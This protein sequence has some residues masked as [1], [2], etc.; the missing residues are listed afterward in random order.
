MVATHRFPPL[1]RTDRLLLRPW[2]VGDAP[3][4]KRAIDDNLE[5]LRAWMAWAMDEPSSLDV[6]EARIEKFAVDFSAG[7]EATYAVLAHD[8]STA[9]GGMGLHAR[10]DD[11]LELGYWIHHAHTRR[12]YATE[13]ARS[14][15]GAAL[16]LP[17]VRQVQIRCDPRNVVSAAVPR[18]LGFR[19]IETLVA[20]TVTPAGAPRDTM[21]WQMTRR[22][23][24]P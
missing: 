8:E 12:G 15:T 13:A 17:D 16:S 6:I 11:G 14:L 23:W 10:I 9:L 22:Q 19:H 3:L 18:R 2:T 20:N 5:H 1:V 7:T 4:L 21:V 24:S